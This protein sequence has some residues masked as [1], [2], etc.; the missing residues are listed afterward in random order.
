[1]S[2]PAVYQPPRTVATVTTVLLAVSA[3]VAML[4]AVAA[5]LMYG[6]ADDMGPHILNGADA[7]VVLSSGLQMLALAGT[8]AAFI[9]WFH[10]VRVNAEVFDPM[11]HRRSR[12][13]AIGGW[14]V[15]FANLWFPREIAVDTWQA[16]TRLDASGVRAPLPHT[17]LNA[18]W[19]TFCAG[20]IIG[21]I[22]SQFLDSAEYSDS[23][24]T[25]ATWLLTADA[26]D[27]VAAGLAIA[28]VQKLTAAQEE[29]HAEAVARAFPGTG[30]PGAPG[31]PGAHGAT[32]WN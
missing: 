2:S 32:A 4:A 5:L 26:L 11:G 10:R 29:R 17:L 30:F 19:V 7:L 8:A 25:A 18:W 14:F 15:P 1:M 13:W 28:V 24:R 22:G 6:S 21:R 9:T 23:Y 16:S 27:V 20:R 31:A 12:G 3:G